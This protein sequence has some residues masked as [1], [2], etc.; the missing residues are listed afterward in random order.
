MIYDDAGATPL[1]PDER[2]GLKHKHITTRGE[3]DELEQAN[4]QTG[5]LCVTRQI[6][7]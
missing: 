4:I 3:L 1:D 6:G 7:T 5:I 2:D